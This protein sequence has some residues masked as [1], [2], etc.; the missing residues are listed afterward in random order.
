MVG[1]YA[2]RNPLFGLIAF[3][4]ITFREVIGLFIESSRFCLLFYKEV[5]SLQEFRTCILV[6]SGILRQLEAIRLILWRKHES[7]DEKGAELFLNAC[8]LRSITNQELFLGER[9]YSW[10]DLLKIKFVR[11]SIDFLFLLL[12]SLVGGVYL[13]RGLFVTIRFSLLLA[14]F[15]SE[16]TLEDS[17]V[18]KHLSESM[19]V[20]RSGVWGR[21]SLFWEYLSSK[22]D[23][24]ALLYFWQTFWNIHRHSAYPVSESQV[25]V[26]VWNFCAVGSKCFDEVQQ[27]S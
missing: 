9:S 5:L 18:V 6:L 7:I 1:M 15:I 22:H 13:F 14:R 16:T 26:V 11:F 2:V 25:E 4:P 8:L 20:Y 3:C 23:I 21:L 27:I 12:F 24:L 17:H 10:K 19:N